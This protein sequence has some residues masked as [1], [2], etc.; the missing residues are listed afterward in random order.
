MDILR[1]TR[2]LGV[3]RTR[4]VKSGHH[5]SVSEAAGACHDD[6]SGIR[7]DCQCARSVVM[8]RLAS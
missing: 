2:A 6:S 4:P 1:F 7:N 5:Y 8:L 3:I